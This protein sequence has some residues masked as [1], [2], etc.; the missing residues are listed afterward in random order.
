MRTLPIF[1]LAAVS[2]T[3]AT[4]AGAQQFPPA[5]GPFPQSPPGG[6]Q[7]GGL[8]PPASMPGP[9]PPGAQPPPQTETERELANAEKKDSGRGLEFFFVNV[10][11]GYEQLSLD[12]LKSNGLTY[13]TTK[14]TDGGLMLGAAAGVRL[15]I[16]TLG[17][18]ARLGKFNQWN[19]GTINAEAG[20]HFPF[21]DLE[22]YLN[23]GV[24][25]A[26]LGA[27]DA[28]TWGVTPSVKGYDVRAGAGLRYY[29]TPVFSIGGLVT[30]EILGLSRA[31]SAAAA[32]ST[33]GLDAKAQSVAKVD[34][35][36]V[37]AAFSASALL[38]L[39]F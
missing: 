1:A 36:S 26:F 34:G 10:E 3:L 12:S 20:L 11:T 24:G 27:M 4:T 14:S 33:A 6:M 22:P 13:G 18:R 35:S 25:Y 17:A 5:P 7:A 31:G 15:V 32:A 30:G 9:P 28:K 19:V 23:F 8:A 38:G 16:L 29:V 2:F 21:G 39:H 37:G